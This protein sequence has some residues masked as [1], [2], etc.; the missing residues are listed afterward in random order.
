[1]IHKSPLISLL[2]R[3]KILFQGNCPSIKSSVSAEATQ[4]D[5]TEIQT[6][7][8]TDATTPASSSR[9]DPLSHDVTADGTQKTRRNPE[10]NG[11]VVDGGRKCLRVLRSSLWTNF[12]FVV[13]CMLVAAVQGCI[14]S[15]L[16][17]LP[18]RGRELGAGPSAAA[19]LL[20]LFGAFDMGGRF[21]FG[22]VFDIRA[23]RR[24]RSYLYTAVA[25]SFGSGAALLAAVDDYVLLATVTCFVAVLEGGAHSQR[26]TS[27]TELVEPSQT[28][29]AVGL[30]IFAQ[31]CG[32]FYGPIIGG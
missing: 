2:T 17:F 30:V 14:Q 25:V 21:V 5:E 23:V 29:L 24:R 19:L 18:S 8:D 3:D 13:Y 4:N 10:S 7:E 1:M 20:T 22:F 6:T 12:P 11:S 31:G 27:V 28:S 32:N 15:V 9:H 16:I 26:A